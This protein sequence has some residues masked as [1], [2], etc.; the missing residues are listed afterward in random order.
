MLSTKDRHI[1][2][3]SHVVRNGTRLSLERHGQPGTFEGRVICESVMS[4]LALVTVDD[5]DFWRNIPQVSFSPDVPALD[6]TVV[7]VGYPLG[8]KSVTVTRGVVSNVHLS[9][10][11]LRAFSEKQMTVQIDAAIN[12]GNSGGPVFN[13]A[14]FKLVGVAFAGRSSAEGQGF[15][16]PIPVVNNFLRL[17]RET[18][19]KNLGLLPSLGIHVRSLENAQ[20]RG[21]AFGSKP[22]HRNGVLV[23]GVKPGTCAHQKIEMGDIIMQ[24]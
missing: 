4:D 10:L 22:T 13:V 18:G 9:D 7:A 23:T 20:M 1:L 5:D 12:P 6:D 8:A 3:N 11:S 17:F 24:A 15:I 14:T 19:Q 21:H 16:I 2:T